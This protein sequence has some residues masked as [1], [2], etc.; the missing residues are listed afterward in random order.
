MAD[1]SK[2]RVLVLDDDEMVRENLK[3]FLEDEGFPVVAFIDGESG[4]SYLQPDMIDVAIVDMRLPG[5][6]G[7]SFIIQSH[8]I[9]PLL[10]YIIHTG[11]SNYMLIEELIEIGLDDSQVF[12]KPVGDMGILV[13]KIYD[14]LGLS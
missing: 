8:K 14:L 7:N 11:S 3:D 13:E 5:M 10:K 9:N 4:L 2:I 1:N 12:I 6:D